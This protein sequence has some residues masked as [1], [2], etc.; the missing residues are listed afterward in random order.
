MRTTR[1]TSVAHAEDAHAARRVCLRG[2]GGFYGRS[3][4]RLCAVSSAG[5]SVGDDDIVAT[6]RFQMLCAC[7][8]EGVWRAHCRSSGGVDRKARPPSFALAICWSE[9]PHTAALVIEPPAGLPPAM[10]A[11]A[12]A[13]QY[14]ATIAAYAALARVCACAVRQDVIEV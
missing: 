6:V 1:N 8:S 3:A 9:D 7:V 13:A 14:A 12:D 2:G 11:T 5:S 10:P 4:V